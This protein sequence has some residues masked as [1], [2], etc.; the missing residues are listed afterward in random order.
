[1]TGLEVVRGTMLLATVAWAAG[2]VLM[3]RSAAA[4]R[5]ARAMW[6]AG[7]ALAVIHTILAFAL[8]YAW[9]H[10]AAVSATSQQAADRFGLGWRGAIYVNYLFLALWLAD[11]CWWWIAPASRAARSRRVEAARVALFLFMFFNGAVVFA[12]TAGRVIG[13]AAV[14]AVLSASPVLRPMRS[15]GRPAAVTSG[16]STSRRSPWPRR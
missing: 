7:I 2:E 9:D 5:T 6:T 14:A 4:D 16:H 8:V 15:I 13:A 11:V 1:M 3:R 10:A 12:S